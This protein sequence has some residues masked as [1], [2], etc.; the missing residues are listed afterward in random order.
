[1]LEA[2]H[3]GVSRVPDKSLT[4][5]GHSNP[6]WGR[7]GPANPRIMLPRRKTSPHDPLVYRKHDD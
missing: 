2:I 7:S 1:L 6:P 5:S 4:P 3:L